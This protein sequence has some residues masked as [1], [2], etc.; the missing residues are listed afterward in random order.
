MKIILFFSLVSYVVSFKSFNFKSRETKLKDSIN[1]LQLKSLLEKQNIGQL[2]KRI[3]EDDVENVYFT[4][5]MKTLYARKDV[6]GDG[7]YNIDDYTVIT[8]DPSVADLVIEHANENKVQT[9]ILEPVV[10]PIQQFIGGIYGF[11]RK[12]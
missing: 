5:D 6:N 12:R 3:D 9:T 1:P 2:I 7:D 11:R 10:N 8:T 4:N